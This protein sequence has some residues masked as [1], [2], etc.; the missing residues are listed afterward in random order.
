MYA[1]KL[2]FDLASPQ[3]ETHILKASGAAQHELSSSPMLMLITR[4]NITRTT[5][6]RTLTRHGTLE[7]PN[8]SITTRPK[9]VL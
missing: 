1:L 2:C 5:V 7:A 9:V 3:I 8:G 6:F 4:V